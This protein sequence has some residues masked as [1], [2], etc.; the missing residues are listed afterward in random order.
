M[1]VWVVQTAQLHSLTPPVTRV[2]ASLS[3]QTYCQPKAIACSPNERSVHSCKRTILV[4]SL[5]CW[6][7]INSALFRGL[8][9]NLN[10]DFNLLEILSDRFDIKFEQF[11]RKE[12]NSFKISWETSHF[13]LNGHTKCHMSS[14][15]GVRCNAHKLQ[16]YSFISNK[17][18][19]WT[20]PFWPH[21][22]FSTFWF[23]CALHAN[24]T[25][26]YLAH[27]Y[28]FIILVVLREIHGATIFGSVVASFFAPLKCHYLFPSLWM[29]WTSSVPHTRPL[30]GWGMCECR[31][32]R[33]RE[34]LLIVGLCVFS[35]TPQKLICCLYH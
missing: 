5:T 27:R 16:P 11:A 12:H 35:G 25:S 30:T 21:N 26:C 34:S 31:C 8:K 22:R 10:C 29:R 33:M 13:P 32:M 23:V 3:T 9:T 14:V 15:F 17:W 19:F 28:V 1:Y 24:S 7:T 18:F 6:K 2:F 20:N 4:H